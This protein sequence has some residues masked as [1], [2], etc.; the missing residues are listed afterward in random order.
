MKQ[1]NKSKPII[2]AQ[3]TSKIIK[4]KKSERSRNSELPR[5]KERMLN[6]DRP[7][8]KERSRNSELPRSKERMLNNDRPR[9]KERMLNNDRSRN[10]ES[11]LNNDRPRSKER[12]LNNDRPRSKE[13]MLNNDRPR[14][15]ERM[16]NNDRPRSK[17]RILNND[18][19]RNKE[20]IRLN[21]YI[22]EAGFVSRRK[23]DEL[24]A[25]GVVKVNRKVVT[26]LGTKI[27]FDDDVV[28]NGNTV[29]VSHKYL[30]ILLNKPKNCI[31][32]TSDEKGRKTIMDIVKIEDRV[33]PVG[34]LDR[35]TT[36]VLLLTNDGEVANILTHPKYQVKRIYNAKLDKVL[37]PQ[38]AQKIASGVDI[39]D[40]TITSPCDILINPEDRHKVMITLTEGK[41][42]EVKKMFEIVG[43]K[44][45]SLDR[46]YYHTLSTK[47]LT[48]GK[49]RFLEKSE[50]A[51]LRK[52]KVQ[53][54]KVP[55]IFRFKTP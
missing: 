13:S 26:E 17:E 10:K 8:S 21:K 7:R 19:P 50:I 44:V 51:E 4:P 23:A 18:R 33:F 42:H 35:N 20:L 47:G 54:N 38:D 55:N 25:S 15:K 1:K 37:M 3:R 12:M 43:Y 53:K 52:I 39:G 40:N 14:S 46:K 24:I 6:N 30:Y 27:S 41:N 2:K 32:S 28:I 29:F 49:Y 48:R 11:M 5:S 22:S 9:S 34:R 31:T 45:K 36:G 16:L